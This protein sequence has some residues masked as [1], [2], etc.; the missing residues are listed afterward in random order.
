MPKYKELFLQHNKNMD[1]KL[2]EIA[3]KL[4]E[5]SDVK[6][7][8]LEILISLGL[9]GRFNSDLV[10]LLTNNAPKNIVNEFI[11]E[12]PSELYTVEI[13]ET[14][15]TDNSKTNVEDIKQFDAITKL[16]KELAELTKNAQTKIKD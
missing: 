6:K 14:D 16:I 3:I 5:T 2:Q 1:A 10:N 12:D 11:N 13:P 15:A 7:D 8:K 9:L 4:T